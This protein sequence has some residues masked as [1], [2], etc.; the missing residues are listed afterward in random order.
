MK[1]I[2]QNL[3]ALHRGIAANTSKYGR[4]PES[5]HIIAVSKRQPAAAIRAAMAAGQRD[6]GENY[7]QEAIPKIETL[8]ADLTWHFIGPL[9][10]NKTRTVAEHFDWLHSLDRAK[11][12]RRL[13]EHRPDALPPLNVCLQVNISG[14]TSKSGVDLAELPNLAAAV[15]ALPRLR[16][17]GLMALPAPASDFE[18]QRR[19][20]RALREAFDS[21]NKAGFGLDTLS[22]GTSTDMA[23]A[24]AEGATHVRIGTAIFGRRDP[25]TPGKPDI[26]Q[27]NHAGPATDC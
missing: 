21:L 3:S 22:M 4:P 20:F 18:Q 11:L 19:P 25:E 10:S 23:A 15:A 14:E 6:F 24:I 17:R 26:H 9:Q 13:Q 2:E 5:V 12:A 1:N 27:G 16:L 8:P 7:L